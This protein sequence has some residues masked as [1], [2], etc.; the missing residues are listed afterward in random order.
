[1]FEK[2]LRSLHTLYPFSKDLVAVP[3]NIAYLPEEGTQETTAMKIVAERSVLKTFALA[4]A[5]G[6]IG[7]ASAQAKPAAAAVNQNSH[8]LARCTRAIEDALDTGAPRRDFETVPM[9]L[10][11]PKQWDQ[12]ALMEVL[13]Y[14]PAPRQ[15]LG[16][17]QPRGPRG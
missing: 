9:I 2:N 6:A 8:R 13:S 11:D 4:H 16:Q 3:H 15:V 7:F 17:Y 1:M 5:T 12:E 10:N 14:R